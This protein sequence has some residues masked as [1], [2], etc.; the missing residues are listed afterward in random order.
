MGTVLSILVDVAVAGIRLV[1]TRR[2]FRHSPDTHVL[3]FGLDL[4]HECI[5]HGDRFH[6]V[7]YQRYLATFLT[8]MAEVTLKYVE[9]G[10]TPIALSNSG[11]PSVAGAFLA[12]RTVLS[13]PKAA[14]KLSARLREYLPLVA[15]GWWNEIPRTKADLSEIQPRSS[16]V[17][18]EIGLG[19]IPAAI[20]LAIEQSSWALPPTQAYWLRTFG[21]VWFVVSLL[22]AVDSDFEEKLRAVRS[23][24]KRRVNNDRG[25]PT[26]P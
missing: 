14:R 19:L 26:P 4:L 3:W 8:S 7:F 2:S 25:G 21:L 17:L 9:Q 6:T 18:R 11:V 24:L 1:L 22:R 16:R 5:H 15:L 10:R 12:W 13:E 20:F 23:I